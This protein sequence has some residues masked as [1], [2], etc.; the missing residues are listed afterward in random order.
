MNLARVVYAP[1]IEPLA[2]AFSVPETALGP[3][4]TAAW[5]GSALPR[6]PTGYLLTKVPRHHVVLG[7]GG[8]LTLAAA[9][10]AFAPSVAVLT[11][12]AFLMG[13]ASGV[14]FI[15]ANPLVSELFP[16]RVGRALGI[17][18]MSAQLAAVFAPGAVVGV[19]LVADWRATFLLIAGLAFVT[20]AAAALAAR[21]ATLP[22]AGTADRDLL[23]AVRGQW[24][25]VLA[26]VAIVGA[27]GF[28]WNGLF[29]FYVSY[30]KVAKDVPQTTSQVLLMVVFAA[31]V[32]AFLFT[33]RLADRLPNVPLLL[34]ILGSFIAVIVVLTVVSGFVA[35]VVVSV[36]LGYVIHSLFP[37]IDTY[38]LGT[39]PD[40]HR[41]SAYSVYSGSMMAIQATGSAAVG[42]LVGGGFTYDA[43]F[44][45]FAGGLV[46]VL[47][48]LVGLYVAGRLPRGRVARV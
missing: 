42:A 2:V 46:V 14:Y 4:A 29:N 32:P 43:V 18:G 19:L 33:G 27:T 1:L 16:D 44:R 39:L 5:L 30:L 13:L 41:G 48:A 45:G 25:I 22:E 9:F 8:V 17:H 40:E 37:A 28:V 20:T 6:V 15:A 35:L 31:G 7:A 3:V 24:R 12:G 11:L 26:G 21:G 47:A 10:T 36:A 23:G 38:L 34:S